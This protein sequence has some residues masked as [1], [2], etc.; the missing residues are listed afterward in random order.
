MAVIRETFRLAFRASE[1]FV[2]SALFC[3]T[4]EIFSTF[5]LY[6]QRLYCSAIEHNLKKEKNAHTH[7]PMLG[8][9]W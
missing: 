5:L 8:C 7:T 2:V 4:E 9:R 3:V 6:L 1:G